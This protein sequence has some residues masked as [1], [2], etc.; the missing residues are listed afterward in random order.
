M[1]YAKQ[2][3]LEAA[4]VEFRELLAMDPDYV[5]AYLQAG[6][7]LEKLKRSEE[8][9]AVYIQGIEAATRRGDIRA[10]GELETALSF[11]A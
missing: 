10:K 1:E 6:Q 5:P 8:A 11:L 2:N 7:T 3:K 4:V 9:R